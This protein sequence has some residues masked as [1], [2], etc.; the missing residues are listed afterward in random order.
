VELQL[1]SAPVGAASV[2]IVRPTILL[3]AALARELPAEELRLV[4]LHELAHV[5]R[6][7][8]AIE[9]LGA[10][11]ACLHWFNPAA[12]LALARL[13][14]ERE[15][16]CDAAVLDRVGSGENNRY[17]HTI[18]K[19]VAMLGRLAPIPGAVGAFGQNRALGRR[20]ETIARHRRSGFAATPLGVTVLVMLAACGLTDGGT[21]AAGP[22][23]S[24]PDA[25]GASSRNQE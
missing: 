19:I 14:Q 21:S 16:A 12:W 3:S 9:R 10:V 8:V 15:L 22:T 11:L 23:A 1:V 25:D 20:I 5:R 6:C 18:L 24:M 13:R 2:G 17:G 4:L 7:D